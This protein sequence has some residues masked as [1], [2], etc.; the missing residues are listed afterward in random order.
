MVFSSMIFLCVFLPVVLVLHTVLPSQK[1]KNVL[2]LLA[3][4]LFYAYGEPVYVLLLLLST[5]LNYVFGRLIGEKSRKKFWLVLS[6][7]INLGLLGVF[8]YAGFLVGSVNSWFSADLPV[9]DIRLPI[10]ISFYT[11]QAMSYVIDVYRNEVKAQKSYVKVLLYISFFP[12]LIAG[13]IVKYHDIAREIDERK[14]SLEEMAAGTRRFLCGLGKKVLLS[15][16]MAAAAD[17]LFEVPLGQ[18]NIL[19]AWL[20]AA[21]YLFQIYFDFSG[22]SDMAIG[23]GKMFGFHF[24]ENFHYPYYSVN[25]QDFWRRWHISL[26]SWF[27]EY[28]YIPLGGNRKGKM[29]T[30]INKLLVFFSTGLWHGA[31]WT[32]VIWGLYHGLFLMLEEYLPIRRIPR[33]L[34]HIYTLLVVCTGFVIFRADTLSQG[35]GIIGKMFSG[36]TFDKLSMSVFMEQLNP[37]FLF[38]FAVCAAAAMPVWERVQSRFLSTQKAAGRTEILL[39]A[40]SIFL[41]IVCMISLSGGAYNPFIYFRF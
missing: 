25:I 24:K 27:K 5:F 9:P 6:V 1:A 16:T 2:L 31:N 18:L 34:G 4:V 23:L 29:R 14:Q 20:G 3:S 21:A 11:F 13:P 30:S 33:F 32:F 10:G 37:L 28:L 7:V 15:N 35:L 39:S 19:G 26:S 38:T 36:F 12:Q 40:G 41:L 8:K 17:A 22:Y